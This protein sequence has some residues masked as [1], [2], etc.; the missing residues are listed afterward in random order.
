M[1]L[2]SAQIWRGKG[3]WEGDNQ[4]EISLVASLN[5]GE[6]GAENATLEGFFLPL[7]YSGPILVPTL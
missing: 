5:A 3:R 4:P 2:P 6:V 1:L 7:S